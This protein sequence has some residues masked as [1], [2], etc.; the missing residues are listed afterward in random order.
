M[1]AFHTR[2]TDDAW[3][4]GWDQKDLRQGSFFFNTIGD[5]VGLTARTVKEVIEDSDNKRWLRRPDNIILPFFLKV[6]A[7]QKKKYHG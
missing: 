6:F 3:E 1:R 7:E 4:Y 5:R 2:T